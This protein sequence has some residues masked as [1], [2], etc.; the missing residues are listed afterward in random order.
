VLVD[1]HQHLWPEELIRALERRRE[2]PRLRGRTLELAAEGSFEADLGAHDP[3]AR[4][5]LLDRRGI[6]LAVLSP[7]PTMEL[8]GRRE[9]ADA[10]HEGALRVVAGGAGRFAALSL[11]E[12]REGFAGVTV[13]AA[14][15]A[16]SP[17]PAGLVLVH[18]GPPAPPPPGAP[19]WW[20]A[21]ADY[22]AQ[23]QA[24]YL[25]WLPRAAAAP[26]VRVVFAMLAGGAPFQLERLASRGAD[27]RPPANA[28]LEV[29]SYGRRALR[30]C[31]DAFGAG[32]LVFGSDAPVL[33]PA[34]TLAEVEA[35]GAEGEAVLGNG[36][37]L[38]D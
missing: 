11:G 32:G 37:R 25:A 35:L 21:L 13:S 2:P 23:M 7:A 14:A 31:L 17:P 4:I 38:L 26:G 34:V 27:P 10:W 19:P 6:D 28:W 36:A 33:D 24:A 15:F 3:A 20:P 12:V 30:L 5:A 29:S 22:T 8:E 1:L 9:L 16:S 18:P